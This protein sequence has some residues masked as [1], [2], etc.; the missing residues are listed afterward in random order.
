MRESTIDSN[1]VQDTKKIDDLKLQVSS[2]SDAESQ[3][4]DCGPVV[5]CVVYNDGSVWRAI[6]DANSDGD[7]SAYPFLTDFRCVIATG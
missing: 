4:I 7:L 1:S 2:L 5:D 6:V 3:Y